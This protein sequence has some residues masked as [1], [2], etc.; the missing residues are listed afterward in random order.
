MH[1]PSR[2]PRIASSGE[3]GLLAIRKEF[4]SHYDD[5][6]T[7]DLLAEYDE[8]I[9]LFREMGHYGE[10]LILE[11]G[12]R[13]WNDLRSSI[14]EGPFREELIMTIALALHAS[15]FHVMRRPLP[16]GSGIPA[17]GSSTSGK[18]TSLLEES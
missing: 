4:L 7:E 18:T 6:S 5:I 17:I 2:D 10:S 14:G 12:R 3:S 1:A 9:R 15:F 11:D 13:T 16:E 8:R